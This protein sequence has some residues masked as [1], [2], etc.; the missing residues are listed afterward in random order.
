MDPQTPRDRARP[1]PPQAEPAPEAGLIPVLRPAAAAPAPGTAAEEAPDLAASPTR[2]QGPEEL[3]P[4]VF[5]P[6]TA[7]LPAAPAPASPATAPLPALRPHAA[8]TRP[9]RDEDAPSTSEAP[10]PAADAPLTAPPLSEAVPT[11][12]LAPAEGPAPTAEQAAETVPDLVVPE[13]LLPHGPEEPR[14]RRRRRKER[15]H[16]RAVFEETLP[17]QAL[18]MVDRLQASPYGRRMRST[19]SRRRERDEQALE[20]RTTLDFALKLGETM[21]GFGATSLDVETSIIVVTQAYGIHETEVD[22]TNQAISLNYAPDSSRGEVPYTLQRVVR[23]Y[24][25]DYEG[26]VAVHRLVEE[27]SAGTVERAEAQRRLVE[28]RHRPKPYPPALE[29]LMAG[30]FVA[31]F[32]PFIGGTWQGA[33]LGMASTWLVFWLH[34]RTMAFLPEIYSV[35]IGSSLATAIAFG[36]YTLDVPINPALVVAGGIMML[37]PTSRFV[38]AVLDAINGFPVTA[39]GRFISTML[40]FIGIMAGIMVAVAAAELAGFPRLDLAAQATA[41][42]PVALLLLLVL[43]A[44]GA[45]AVV[46]RSGWRTLLAS[47]GVAGVAFCAHALLGTLG[48][49]PA[50]KAAAAAAVVG[51]LGRIVALRVGAPPIVV[52][53]PSILFLLPGFSIFRGLYEFTV[54]TTSTVLGVAGIVSALVVVVGIGAGAVFGDT[55]ARPLTARLVERRTAGPEGHQR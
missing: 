47:C 49:G 44:T 23:S 25:T 54:E 22:L 24:S 38:T 15:E 13:P 19:L 27:I 1:V 43:V 55:L 48:V 2:A 33:L 18:V 45:D 29:I 46:E 26:L 36:A 52:M 28:V 6:A 11:S 12:V 51:F 39:A 4:P 41:S 20:A 34:T 40:V 17:T 14:G 42:H 16:H 35:M 9:D 7:A 30:V 21:F 37:M 3:L 8:P 31:C 32:I 5:A 10:A 53:V 50:L